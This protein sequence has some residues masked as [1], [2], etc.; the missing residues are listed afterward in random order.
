M[1]LGIEPDQ[2]ESG[3]RERGKIMKDYSP[4]AKAYKE[5]LYALNDAIKNLNSTHSIYSVFLSDT[6]YPEV[7]D[8][9][10]KDVLA[11]ADAYNA[12]VREVITL[13]M[14]LDIFIAIGA[15]KMFREER[16]ARYEA[17]M[18]KAGA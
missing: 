6:M 7:D 17:V 3:L 1:F 13:T 12:M 8:K 2:R 16:K 11:M 4:D 9:T 5:T 14:A 15:D 18:A 10:T